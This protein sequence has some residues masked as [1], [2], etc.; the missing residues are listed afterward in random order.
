[1]CN[2][3]PFIRQFH[4]V[5]Q[6][7]QLNETNKL[8]YGAFSVLHYYKNANQ[9]KKTDSQFRRTN[10]SSLLISLKSILQRVLQL[11][12]IQHLCSMSQLI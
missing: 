5:V 6:A 2:E 1:M 8:A 3:T 12:S 11:M 4:S 7:E 9:L 10:C